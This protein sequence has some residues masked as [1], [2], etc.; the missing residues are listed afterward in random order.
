M[1]IPLIVAG[2]VAVVAVIGA[3]GI[4]VVKEEADEQDRKRRR[5]EQ[6]I[7]AVAVKKRQQEKSVL[8]KE[9]CRGKLKAYIEKYKLPYG[10]Q[11]VELDKLTNAI[12]NMSKA[13]INEEMQNIFL[14]TSIISNLDRE[15]KWKKT[16]ISQQEEADNYLT[17]VVNTYDS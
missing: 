17:R 12:K 6:G 7:A 11:N 3:A 4:K 16:I 10:T 8:A 9:Y 1:P 13:Q 5:K 2:I 15:I 14:K